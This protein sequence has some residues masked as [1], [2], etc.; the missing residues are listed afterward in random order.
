MGQ[1]R[2]AEPDLRQL[3]PLPFPEQ[4]VSG[5]DLEPVERELAVPAMFFRPHDRNAPHD[6][7]ARLVPVEQEGRQARG[8]DRPTYARPG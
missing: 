4:H 8:A 7:P 3:Q 5:R 1:A 2:R 6:A